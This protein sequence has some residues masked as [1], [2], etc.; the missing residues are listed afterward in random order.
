MGWY[1]ELHC[2]TQD[3]PHGHDQEGPQGKSVKNVSAEARRIGWIQDLDGRWRCDG[4][5]SSFA[6]PRL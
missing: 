5:A 3:C 6:A 4:C 2:D 1:I